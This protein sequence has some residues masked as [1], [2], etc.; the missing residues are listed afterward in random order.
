MYKQINLI[1]GETYY[2]NVERFEKKRNLLSKQNSSMFYNDEF[3]Y[4][5][6]SKGKIKQSSALINIE[7]ICSI[8]DCNESLIVV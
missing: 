3:L 5:P 1:N 6:A 4:E 8:T 2:M 7:S